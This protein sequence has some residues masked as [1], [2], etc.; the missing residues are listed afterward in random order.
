MMQAL[1]PHQPPTIIVERRA[2]AS[3]LILVG[4][5]LTGDGSN[6]AKAEIA[7]SALGFH[8]ERARS[9]KNE[10]ETMILF[11]GA[12]ARVSAIGFLH[13]VQRGEYGPLTVEV[14]L[15]DPAVVGKNKDWVN[16]LDV[17][18]TGF[19]RDPAQ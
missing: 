14:V 6:R 13:A 1:P 16:Q 11:D 8:H 15:G 4:L 2:D 10:P 17:E 3:P 9:P 5:V 7:A 19:I 12:S 18:P